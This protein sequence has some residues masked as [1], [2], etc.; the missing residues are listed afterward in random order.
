[1][2]TTEPPAPRSITAFIGARTVL[3]AYAM[4]TPEDLRETAD[5]VGKTGGR[6]LT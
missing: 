4:A 3:V 6:V 1:M 2:M 5:L